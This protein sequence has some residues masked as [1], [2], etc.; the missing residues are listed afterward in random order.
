MQPGPST[1][2]AGASEGARSHT[3][4]GEHQTIAY[5]IE[6]II[7]AA[8][9]LVT[10]LQQILVLVDHTQTEITVHCYYEFWES[11]FIRKIGTN[12]VRLYVTLGHTTPIAAA[13]VMFF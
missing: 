9:A 7:T 1:F 11:H 5:S 8:D 13:K 2:R 12:K 4:H 10:R 6:L 3:M